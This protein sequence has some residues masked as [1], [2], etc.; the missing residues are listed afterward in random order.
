MKVVLFGA[1]ASFGAGEIVPRPPPLGYDLFPALRRLFSTWRAIP[2]ADAALF[3]GDFEAGMATVVDRYSMAVGP[4]MQEMALFFSGFG[5]RQGSSNLYTRLI[6]R[7]ADCRDVIWSTLNYECLLEVAA[8]RTGRSVHYFGEPGEELEE[9]LPIWK[10]HGSCNFKVTGLQAG[11]GVHYG[12]GVVF[13]GGIEPIDPSQVRAVYTANTSLYPAMALFAPDK[14]IA[15]SPAPIKE[16]QDR[17]A[18]HVLAAEQVVVVGVNPNPGDEHI[19]TPLA[20][21]E[22]EVSF[23]GSAEPFGGWVEEYRIPRPSHFLADRWIHAEEAVGALLV[24]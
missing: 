15:M 7:A 24:C 8:A 18:A 17:W 5:Q 2:E 23:V 16:A 12:T 13:G 14:P 6:E 1:G 21:T 11:R 4:L 3:A 19:W 10:L 20:E 22:A 9:A